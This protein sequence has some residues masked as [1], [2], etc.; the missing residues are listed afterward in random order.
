MGSKLI[1]LQS[2]RT[3][4]LATSANQIQ[5]A[6]LAADVSA[7]QF[8]TPFVRVVRSADNSLQTSGVDFTFLTACTLLTTDDESAKGLRFVDVVGYT[9]SA[10]PA[11]A[12]VGAGTNGQTFTAAIAS[13]VVP[14]LQNLGGLLQWKCTNPSG[15]NTATVH[16]EIQLICR[17]P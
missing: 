2:E 8:V 16:F 6:M 12:I 4:Y 7:Y 1:T 13:G 14:A 5:E 15:V 3:I 11:A 9:I 17:G 10:A